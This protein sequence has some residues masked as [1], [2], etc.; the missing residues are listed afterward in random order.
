MQPT[1]EAMVER[2][3]EAIAALRL[4]AFFQGT[5]RTL[6]EDAA[7]LRGL[8]AGDE[9]EAAFVARPR[10]QPIG[11]CLLVRNEIDPAHDLTPWL[12]GL[13]VEEGHRGRGIGAALVRTVEAH[14]IAAGVDTLHLYTW[15]ARRFYETLG[16]TVVEPFEQ[17]G[18]PM[19]LMSRQL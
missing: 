15:R 19:L 14:A 1:I 16:W 12:A 2:D 18:E 11:S 8:L 10:G 13:V 9:L 3:V 5:G 4:A 17:D 6:D 7:G